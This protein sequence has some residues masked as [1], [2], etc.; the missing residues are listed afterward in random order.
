MRVANSEH[1]RRISA[2]WIIGT[3]RFVNVLLRQIEPPLLKL[4]RHVGELRLSAQKPA[5]IGASD[6]QLAGGVRDV[7]AMPA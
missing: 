1:T 6:A 5:Q 2:S 7:D 3:K 4:K